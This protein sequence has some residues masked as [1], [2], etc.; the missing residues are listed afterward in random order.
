MASSMELAVATFSSGL[1]TVRLGAD[2]QRSLTL[3][4]GS[5]A[6]GALV[7]R[8]ETLPEAVKIP[9]RRSARTASS[10]EAAVATFSSEL[11]AARY[12]AG[13]RRLASFGEWLDG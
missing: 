10:A 4:T 3:S 12:F 7:Y 13:A 11:L 1:L 5:P 6:G 8:D 2:A 9:A